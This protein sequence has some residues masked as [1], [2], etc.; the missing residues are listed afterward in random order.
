MVMKY[1]NGIWLMHRW[2]ECLDWCRNFLE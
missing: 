1:W 2:Q